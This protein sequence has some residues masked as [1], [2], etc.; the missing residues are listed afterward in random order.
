MTN[1]KIHELRCSMALWL[2]EVW[3]VTDAS[4]VLGWSKEKVRRYAAAGE[5]RRKLALR[6]MAILNCPNPRCGV[7]RECLGN[8]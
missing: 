5:R 2:C 3:T 4:I 8:L 7:C 1:S 6:R